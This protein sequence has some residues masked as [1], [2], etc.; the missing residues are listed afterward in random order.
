[1]MA[2]ALP[3]CFVGLLVVPVFAPCL[4]QQPDTPGTPAK[5]SPLTSGADTSAG[6]EKPAAM[7]L[8]DQ[9][10]ADLA[11]AEAE[12]PVDADKVVKALCLLAQRQSVARRITQE[13][14]DLAQR[15]MSM[16]EAARGHESLL[17][18]EALARLAL[19]Y[20]YQDHA[21]QARPLSEEA[22]EIAQRTGP[23]TL[24]LAMV[25]DGLNRVCF[26]LNDLPCSLRAAKQ[27]VEAVRASHTADHLYLASLLQNQAQTQMVLK[28][29]QGARVAMEESIN[30]CDRETKVTPSMAVM[31][32][33]ASAFY[34]RVNDLEA[35][36]KHLEKA[37]AY[38]ITQYGSDSEQAGRISMNLASLYRKSGRL[39]EA[40]IEY[41]KADAQF[42]RWYGSSHTDTI[43]ME[44]GYAETLASAG[45][46]EEALQMAKR[47]HEALREHLSLAIRVMPERQALAL[48]ELGDG[49]MDIVLSIALRSPGLETDAVFQEEIRSRALVTE[50]M[51]QR[52]ASLNRTSDPEIAALL[53]DLE[54]ER[55]AVL[56]AHETSPGAAGSMQQLPEATSRMERIERTLAE[57]SVA[58]RANQRTRS[59]ALDDVHHQ[60]PPDSVLVSYVA[61]RRNS[62]DAKRNS[63]GNPA[64]YLAFVLHPDSNKIDVF[65]LGEGKGI[66]ALV[67]KARAAAESEAHDNGLASIRNERAYREAAGAL[68]QRIWD[69]LK[70]D[71]AGA[72][73]A[74]VVADGK[75]I[76]IPFSSLPDGK[77]YMVEHGP[78]I[79]MLTSERDLVPDDQTEKKHGLL[80][81][82]NPAFDHV[83]AASAISALRDGPVSCDA[84]RKVEFR[85]LPG[86]AVEVTDVGSSWRR[87]N[88]RESALLITGENATRGRFLDE[89]PQSRVLH[90]AT[91]AFLLDK[92]CGN[93][94][95]LLHSGLVFAGGKHGEPS[96]I[97]TAQQIASLDLSGADWAVL[98]ACNTG[99]GELRDGEG[100]LSL[101]RAFR[102]AGVRSVVMTLWP[103]D[104]ETTREFMH[105]L[106]TERLG[107]HSSTA[108][109]LWNSAR[110]L[111][112][113][114][115]AAGKST[116]PW[117][118][119]GFV[120]SGGWE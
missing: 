105:D 4:G 84:F 46:M 37:K 3:I 40:L 67:L 108:N 56:A 112:L 19:V 83:P 45:R 94:N 110:E 91:H 61:F 100:V 68:R 88:R 60:M 1:M 54:K 58:F 21:E 39:Q 92:N 33:N 47:A 99:N 98:S 57:R 74:L 115:R 13:T 30:I 6:K 8:I 103:V 72:K 2:G 71:L 53:K 90:I 28:D 118:W 89:A 77:G 63:N 119:A 50:E 22:L 38:T 87:W 69:P 65:D 59:V 70:G 14:I 36:L 29:T 26:S 120:G 80:A 81:I 44:Q 107:R 43:R 12:R 7:D 23:G 16:A 111:L 117:Y 95:P 93:G 48:T 116:H 101:Q 49:T 104:D 31:E 82:G 35:A 113:S 51:A 75:L 10:R 25:A 18:A 64:W 17:Y 27:S 86:T 11:K 52:A 73:L 15:A 41:E 85:P 32:S 96:T 9:A 79:H 114:R 97:L 62:F 109:A 106:Y 20:T 5:T 24:A 55:S 34:I 66:D 76:L 78:V 102:V 42:D